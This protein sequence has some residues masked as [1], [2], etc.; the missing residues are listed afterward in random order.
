MAQ[1]EC[2]RSKPAQAALC[3]MANVQLDACS[4]H[5]IQE[6]N[7]ACRYNVLTLDPRV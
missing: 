3:A 2:E 5:A 4:M 1:A 6:Q 7:D